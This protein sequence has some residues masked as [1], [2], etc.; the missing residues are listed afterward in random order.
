MSLKEEDCVPS[1]EGPCF[2]DKGS[3]DPSLSERCEA[4]R[5]Q[6]RGTGPDSMRVCVCVFGWF[7]RPCAG[8]SLMEKDILRDWETKFKN[9]YPVVG[10][11][12]K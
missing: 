4:S 1:T 3:D 11:V 6:S 8:L 12:K 2:G 7:H 5:I 9:K 10:T